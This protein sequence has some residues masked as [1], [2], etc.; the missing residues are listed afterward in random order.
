MYEAALDWN[1][2]EIPAAVLFDLLLD[3]SAQHV[4]TKGKWFSLM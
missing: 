4:V 3:A 2:E 1:H